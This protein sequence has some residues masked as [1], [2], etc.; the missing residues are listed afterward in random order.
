VERRSSVYVFGKEA[1]NTEESSPFL[2]GK[3]L[4]VRI[5]P[6]NR[7]KILIFVLGLFKHYFTYLS[8]GPWKKSDY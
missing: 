7:D 1:T 2:Q 5:T 6:D 3:K 4:M 8:G